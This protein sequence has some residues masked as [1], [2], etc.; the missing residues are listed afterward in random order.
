MSLSFCPTLQ[1]HY[2]EIPDGSATML[3]V[4]SCLVSSK[5]LTGDHN[6]LRPP[7][8]PG[9]PGGPVGGL[10]LG[11]GP[12][13]GSSTPR[14]YLH[15]PPEEY[16]SWQKHRAGLVGGSRRFQG[17]CSLLEPQSLSD[18]YDTLNLPPM[19]GHHAPPP[20]PHRLGLSLDV[21]SSFEGGGG[22]LGVEGDM[23]VSPNVIN[24]RRGGL[25]EQRDIVKAHQAHKIQSTPQARR[26]EW[27]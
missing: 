3:E 9:G 24:R 25:I 6:A 18:S 27:E 7:C 1:Q 13:C 20:H 16:E 8:S 11:M 14:H 2:A 12:V 21:G 19:S 22:M 4:G 15:P 10:G 5:S 17:S 26:K 23:A